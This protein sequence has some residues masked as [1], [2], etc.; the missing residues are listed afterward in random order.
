VLNDPID[1]TDQLGTTSFQAS[2]G[3]SV[4]LPDN[5]AVYDF[6]RDA[7]SSATPAPGSSAC[8]SD[9][10]HAAAASSLVRNEAIKNGSFFV[11]TSNTGRSLLLQS[12]GTFNGQSGIYEYIIPI[13]G[14]L[15]GG[16]PTITHQTFIPGAPISGVPNN[17]GG[18]APT[19]FPPGAL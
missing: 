18:K 16:S 15:F 11:I 19:F 4:N 5:D 12:N 2:G 9:A 8:K 6:V 3:P 14:S 13:N 10:F 17:W 7:F 1:L